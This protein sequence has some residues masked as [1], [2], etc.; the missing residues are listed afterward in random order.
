MD[1]SKFYTPIKVSEI[2]VEDINVSNPQN[3]I[4]ICCGSC[5]LLKAASKRWENARILGVDINESVKNESVIAIMDGRQYALESKEKYDVVLANPPFEKM[6]KKRENPFLYVKA[7]KNYYTLRLEN[8]M[9]LANLKLLNYNGLLMIILPSTFV[10]GIINRKL[11][12]ILAR[13][14]TIER[15]V[16]LPNDTFGNTKIHTYA[17][18]I[19]NKKQNFYV[20]DWIDL[21]DNIHKTI[22]HKQIVNGLWNFETI[23]VNVNTYLIIKRGKISSNMFTKCGVSVLHTSKKQENSKWEPSVKKVNGDIVSK[24]NNV[25]TESG[26]I[27]V[28]RIG[29]DA[30]YWTKYN[31]KKVLVSDC[32]IIIKDQNDIVFNT[33][34]NYHRLPLIKG[35]ATQYITIKDFINWYASIQ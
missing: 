32:L 16:K 13:E 5:N 21:N 6:K 8:E 18:Y 7:F 31:G 9:L 4:D 29:K 10:E 27:I 19:V 15:I 30:G 33:I 14:Y 26:D 17:I 1:Y 23:S 24:K 11:R 3:V 35:V 22:N 25:Y 28:N 12:E 34:K 2:L 20:T